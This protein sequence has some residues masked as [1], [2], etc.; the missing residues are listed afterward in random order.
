VR[1]DHISLQGLGPFHSRVD[2]DLASIPGRIVAVCGENGAGKSTLLELLAGALYRQTPTRGTLVELAT[3]RNA[4]VEA[5]VVNGSSWT[6]RHTLDAISGKGEAL[7]LD[8]AGAPVL[9]DTKVRSFDAWRAAHL[10]TPEVLY[11]SMFAPQGSGG[12]LELK[13][14]D[15]KAVLLRV[16]GIEA[17]ECQAEGARERQRGAKQALDILQARIADER[18]RG[19]DVATASAQLLA[20]QNAAALVDGAIAAC[21][22]DLTETE[23]KVAEQLEVI[24]LAATAREKHEEHARSLEFVTRRAEDLHRRIANNRGVLNEA[25]AI[26]AAVARATRLAADLADARAEI[27]RVDARLTVLRAEKD[28]ATRRASEAETQLKT[29]GRRVDAAAQRLE[30]RQLIEG[31]VRDLP[32]H[33][34]A[35][36]AAEQED[37]KLTAELESTGLKWRLSDERRIGGLR[38]GL[39]V[40]ADLRDASLAGAPDVACDTLARDEQ[41]Q[42]DAAQAPTEE[43]GLKG[44]LAAAKR[45]VDSQ[46]RAIA[47]LEVLAARAPEMQAAADELAAAEA[48][49]RTL[50]ANAA[51]PSTILAVHLKEIGPIEDDRRRLA[52][53]VVEYGN[54]L[55]VLVPTADKAAHLMNAEAR[56][57]ELEPQLADADAERARL[58]AALLPE[59]PVVPHQDE[60]LDVAAAKRAI[61]LAEDESKRAHGMIAVAE[62]RLEQARLAERQWHHLDAERRGV[63]SDLADWSLLADSLGRDGIQ[64]L[65][66]D[67]AGPELTELINDLLRSCVGSRWT[68]TIETTRASADG[69]RQLEGCE[70]RVL[71]CERGRDAT[72]E[73]LSGGERVLVGEAVSLALS[74]MACRRVGMR[75]ATLIRDESG[76]ALDPKNARNYVAMLR[77]AAELVDASH[78]LFV[79]HSR[80]VQE[81]ADARIEIADGKVTVAA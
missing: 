77:R 27:V 25:E 17:L 8:G 80:E 69:K 31:A 2:L 18:A 73:T 33:L 11:S 62:A 50:L 30:K 59:I 41:L 9:A 43:Q 12:F 53:L 67:A 75:G 5:R 42:R 21:R 49:H 76:A 23:R 70:V 13:P 55:D 1:F 44:E 56:L 63:E 45:E 4:F 32:G 79:S 28:H 64:A 40:I 15:R 57:A 74:M 39:G 36:V 14:G 47:A 29:V 65:E 38:D 81:L 6:L 48:E 10:P 60:A 22:R 19:L 52:G 71:D 26:R 3:D 37:K 68:V 72:A 66:V 51:A 61:T 24:R 34:E 58:D 46:R 54:E 7:V 20:A 35:L 16:L 78:V